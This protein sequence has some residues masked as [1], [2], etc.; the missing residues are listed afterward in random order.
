MCISKFLFPPLPQVVL[1]YIPA[2][3]LSVNPATLVLS[4]ISTS[5]NPVGRQF[6]PSHSSITE[7]NTLLHVYWP[8]VFFFLKAQFVVKAFFSV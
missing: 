7:F 1:I 6:L 4:I 3:T 2:S 8:V 5:V